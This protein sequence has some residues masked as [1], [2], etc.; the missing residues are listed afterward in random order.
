MPPLQYIQTSSAAL[1]VSG[2][3]TALRIFTQGTSQGKV[4]LF[5]TIVRRLFSNSYEW[6]T[7][8]EHKREKMQRS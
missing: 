3:A 1:V 8:D 4:N 7:Q 6:L 2:W 5:S